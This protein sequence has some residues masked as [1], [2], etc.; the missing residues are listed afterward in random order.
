ML[1]S[2][3]SLSK[4]HHVY[5]QKVPGITVKTTSFSAENGDAGSAAAVVTLWFVCHFRLA[6]ACALLAKN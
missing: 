6:F 4:F 2:H 5:P 3:Q 1:F